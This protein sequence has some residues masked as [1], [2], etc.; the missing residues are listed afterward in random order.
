VLNV[1]PNG[2]EGGIWQAGGAMAADDSG[3]I[4][5]VVGNGTFDTALDASGFPL[6]NDYGNAFIK[7]STASTLQVIDYFTMDNTV[8][9]SNDDLDFG[10]G[11]PMLLPDQTDSAGIV[12]HL[13]V[14][15][16]KDGHL[17]VVSRDNMGKFSV[18][19]N[20]IWEDMPGALAG[21]IWSSPAYF[22]GT[23]YYGP[24]ASTLKAFGINQALLG[25]T[26]T[27]QTTMSFSYPGTSPSV[28]ANGSAN[29]IVWAVENSQPAVLHAFA[30]GNLATELYNSNQAA[31]GR[32]QIGNGNKFMT[33]TIANGKVY[34]GTPT[35]VAVF[36][37]LP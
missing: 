19:N 2:S 15:A 20:A 25:V 14:G 36:G 26:P 27:S 16:G 5:A 28:S 9:E 23:V 33:P 3:N 24:R 18:S 35:G 31:N 30:A 7:I 11:A 29:G 10:S 13:A 4:Y 1:T 32:D 37:L 21:G 6:W 22:Q 12:Q 17:Y 8:S 34:V